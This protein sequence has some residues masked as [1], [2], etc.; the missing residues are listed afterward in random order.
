MRLGIEVGGTFTDLIAIDGDELRLIKVPSTPSEPDQAVLNAIEAAAIDLKNVEEFVHG[1]TV[2]TNAILER[3]GAK[4]AFITTEG[5]RDILEIQRHDRSNIYDIA[6]Q[7]PEPVVARQHCYEVRERIDG[8]G[9]IVSP[10]DEAAVEELLVPQLARHGYQSLAICLLNSYENP[11]HEQRLAELLRQRLPDVQVTCSSDV[12]REFREYERASTTAL[13]AYV[14]PVING[15]LSRLEAALADRGFGGAFSVM[16]SNGGRLPAAGMRRNCISAFLSGPAAGVVGGLRQAA[17]SGY[18]DVI[19]FDMGGTSTDV[20]LVVDGVPQIA[21]QSQVG[22]LPIRS[23]MVDIATIGAGGGSIVWLD[24]GGMFRVGPQSAGA[25]PG[26][27]CYGKG[28]SLPT[29]TDAHVICGTIQPDTFLGGQMQLSREKAIAA[30]EPIAKALGTSVEEAADNALT[31]ATANIVRAIQTVSTQ[32]GRD[33]RDYA[34]VPFGG[35]GPLCA[36]EIASELGTETVVVPPNPGVLSAFGLLAS[37]YT[38]V[39]VISVHGTT[40]PTELERLRDLV[41]VM[42]ERSRKALGEL[43]IGRDLEFS[44]ILDMRFTGQAFEIQ[45]PMTIAEVEGEEQEGIERRFRDAYSKVF[46]HRA[47]GKRPV[48]IVSAR[49]ITINRSTMPPSLDWAGDDDDRGRQITVRRRCK[50]HECREVSVTSLRTRSAIPGP[51]VLTS[52]TS[53][54]FVEPGW[55][56]ERDEDNNLLV[57]RVK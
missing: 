50:R 57:R 16:Q 51:V 9:G 34:L 52:E 55:K 26:P 8:R 29:I 44:S 19:S 1:S 35:A 15:Y 39:D 11:A 21:P 53:S 20:C 23:P 46:Y 3:K 5:F 13:A 28:G 12:V 47:P 6:Y 37:D 14:Q 40:E 45:V 49:L 7:K 41:R 2:A 17:Q 31:L 24:E 18:R 25:S 22:G 42:I 30:F 38:S 36:T 27:A 56:A 33:P 10:L 43:G 4:T 32:R 54:L 48:E